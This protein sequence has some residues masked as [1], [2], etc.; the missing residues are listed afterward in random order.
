MN[1]VLHIGFGLRPFWG[2]GMVIYQESMMKAISDAGWSVSF[3][4]TAPRYDIYYKPYVKISI[5]DKIRILEIVNSPVLPSDY[6]SDPVEHCKNAVVES[7]VAKI[8]EK[9][10]PNVIHLHDLRTYPVSIIDEISSRKIPMVKT[11]HNYWDLCPQGDLIFKGEKVCVDFEEGRLCVRCLEN[12]PAD[13]ISLKQ[14]IIGSLFNT[15]F[16]PIG[17]KLWNFK[18]TKWR[19]IPG[20][21]KPDVQISYSASAYK[22]RRQFFVERLNRVDRIHSYSHG[23]ADILEHY[24]VDKNRIKVVPVSSRTLDLITQRPLRGDG[25]P[26]VF[27]Y[28]GGASYHKGFDI[29][30]DAFSKLDQKKAKLVIFE[31]EKFKVLYGRGSLNIEIRKRYLPSQINYFFSDIDVG[32]VPSVW[33]EVFGIIG[34]EFLQARIP[35]IGSRIGGIPEWLKEEENGFF[36]SPGNVND[37]AEKMQ[38]FINK[39]SLISQ[40]QKQIR[41]WKS[42]SEHGREILDLY[43]GML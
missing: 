15:P 9:E 5:K 4:T 18:A 3:L 22:H 7:I 37:L 30:L 42:M 24:G 38:R 17:K 34:I 6:H 1:K 32:I 14:R 36:V 13:H 39:P 41:P 19:K 16:Y 43:N 29:I 27:G 10:K 12:F 25:Y 35:V 28:C 40:F 33:E 2:G 23:V 8:I 11:V 20:E 31:T 26:I 21:K